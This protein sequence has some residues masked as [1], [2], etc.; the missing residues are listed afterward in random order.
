[1]KLKHRL[2]LWRYFRREVVYFEFRLTTQRINP[3]DRLTEYRIVQT[4]VC[5]EDAKRQE[6]YAYRLAA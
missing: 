1:M 2:H 6:L 5:T 4:A 3:S